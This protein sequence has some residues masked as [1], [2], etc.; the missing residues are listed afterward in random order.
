MFLFDH[1]ISLESIYNKFGYFHQG[2]QETRKEC[3]ASGKRWNGSRKDYNFD[4]L[5]NHSSVPQSNSNQFSIAVSF[6][7]FHLAF[8]ASW[9]A[10]SLRP[11]VRI[12]NILAFGARGTADLVFAFNLHCIRSLQVLPQDFGTQIYHSRWYQQACAQKKKQPGRFVT[13]RVAEFMAGLCPGLLCWFFVWCRSFFIFCQACRHIGRVL[14]PV[15]W[16]QTWASL[17]HGFLRTRPQ[18]CIASFPMQW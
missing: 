9:Q 18:S 3:E 15:W 14:N 6:F 4:F 11:H 2:L 10:A 8:A 12:R 13:P 7:H 16:S 5:G 17:C 1:W